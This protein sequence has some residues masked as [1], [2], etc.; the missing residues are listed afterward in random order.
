MTLRPKKNLK[1]AMQR[2]KSAS[3][4]VHAYQHDFG[5]ADNKQKAKPAS[6]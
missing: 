2:Q 4:H 5:L 6:A 3:K 1:L